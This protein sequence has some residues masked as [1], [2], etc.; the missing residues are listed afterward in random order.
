[1]TR[2]LI[3]V[4]QDT[5]QGTAMHAR[6]LLDGSQVLAKYY[7]CRLVVQVAFAYN[8]ILA[9]FCRTIYTDCMI[10]TTRCSHK[11]HTTRTTKDSPS[12]ISEGLD[13]DFANPYLARPGSSALAGALKSHISKAWDTPL[14]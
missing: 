10:T 5:T 7:T 9:G 13:L 14:K 1:M 2:G 8:Y 3:A 12:T 11:F 4:R 6:S